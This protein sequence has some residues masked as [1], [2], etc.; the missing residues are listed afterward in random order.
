MDIKVLNPVLK[1]PGDLINNGISGEIKTED[2]VEKTETNTCRSA[3]Q[4]W[5]SFFKARSTGAFPVAVL[6]TAF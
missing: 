3:V 2:F 6:L 1:I 5:L 4:Q